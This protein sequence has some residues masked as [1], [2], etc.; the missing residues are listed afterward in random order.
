MEAPTPVI[1]DVIARLKEMIVSE[2][3][4]PGSRLP[5]ERDLAARLT[6]SRN[7]VREAVRALS[8]TGIVES[9]RGSGTY[10]TSLAPKVMLDAMSLLVD[11]ADD[12]GLVDILAV[13]RVLEAEAAARAAARITAS[14][15][16]ELRTCLDLMQHDPQHGDGSVTAV[17]EADV[18]FH[19][20]IAAASGNPVLAA[21]IDALGDRT[22]RGRVWRAYADRGVFG[23]ACVE[24]EAIYDALVESDPTRA[25]A[26]A[27]AH[28]AQVERFLRTAETPVDQKITSPNLAGP[29]D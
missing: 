12:V 13:R 19:S 7:T 2:G 6:V 4:E 11:F 28:V 21:L 16:A 27:A 20:V 29:I 22:L 18:R 17:T 1:D 23:R 14:E 5:P 24:H 25:A 8:L 15:L 3:Y 10:V 9:R 26:A